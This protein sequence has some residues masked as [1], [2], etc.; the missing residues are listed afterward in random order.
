M[1]QVMGPRGKILSGAPS[2]KAAGSFL[3][4]TN[5]S[6]QLTAWSIILNGCLGVAVNRP[7]F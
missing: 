2:V 6:L 5:I 4:E 7:F 1:F 3:R